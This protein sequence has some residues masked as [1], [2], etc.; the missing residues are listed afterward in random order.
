MEFLRLLVLVVYLGTPL[1]IIWCWWRFAAAGRGKPHWSM[2]AAL[3][4]W[5]LQ[6]GVLLYFI[7]ICMSGHCTLTPLQEHGPVVLLVGAYI[8][9]GGLLWIAWRKNRGRS[10]N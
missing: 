2:A 1:L 6:A 7:A 3:G 10:P 4:L 8:G 9:I 5:L